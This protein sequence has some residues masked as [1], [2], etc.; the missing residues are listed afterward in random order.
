MADYLFID[1]HLHSAF[2]DEDLCDESPEHILGK[3]Q[4]YCDKYNQQ[5]GTD[6]C[7]AVALSDH[8]TIL[9][10]VNAQE[11]LAS[12]K[13]PNVRLINGCEFTVDLRELNDLIGMEHC[14]TR[15]HLH[16][17]NYDITNEELLAYSKIT[18]KHYS[19]EDN[20]GLQICA[21]RRAV[22]EKYK[23][24]IPFKTFLPLV[25]LPQ[26]ANY[27]TEFIKI[28]KSYFAEKNKEFDVHDV[29]E[30]IEEYLISATTYVEPATAMGR[31]KLSEA[32]RL[33]KN[34]GG[35]AVLAHPAYM[36]VS[37]DGLKDI[38]N[39]QGYDGN[40]A[41]IEARK[42]TGH[43]TRVELS[44]LDNSISKVVLNKFLTLSE[45]LV[46]G[47]RIDGMETYY[48]TNFVNRNDYAIHE[49]CQERNMFETCGSDYHGE[50]FAS[51]KT[52]GNVFQQYIQHNYGKMVER[53]Q[54]RGLFIRLA[55]LPYVDYVLDGDKIP[56]GAD[57]KFVDE[58]LVEISK[59]N[60]NKFITDCAGKPKE[61]LVASS[62]PQDRKLT[63]ADQDY[64]LANS[65]EI[66]A[67]IV[68]LMSIAENYNAILVKSATFKDRRK[69][70]L[71]LE[72]FCQSVYSSIKSMQQQF[73]EHAELFA[74]DEFK[75]ITTLLKEIHRKYY[76]MLRLDNGIMYDLKKSLRKK[77]GINE[78]VIDK[79]AN[80]TIKQCE[81][82]EDNP[83]K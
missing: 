50:N 49:L 22:C 75:Q 15:C 29:Y 24:N 41:Y 33:I 68:S 82:L 31:L 67:N 70:L 27:V 42:R 30:A 61:A 47:A 23:I 1:M 80:I 63:K 45:K 10:C 78:T 48:G 58:N 40:E 6:V 3:L 77:Y 57:C 9:G 37:L 71:K 44:K 8:N 76:E 51:H 4:G 13:F 81:K 32:L 25:D 69:K 39:S 17:F 5:N 59:R 14:F 7:C 62:K 16:G 12:G 38:L 79:I 43:R 26:S 53:K 21:A 36:S 18:H 20:I 72:I 74:I 55:N 64:I 54:Y 65:R 52:I 35:N 73:R 2:S 66:H 11:L 46:K 19:N 34:A 28:V 60:I 56:A 83:E